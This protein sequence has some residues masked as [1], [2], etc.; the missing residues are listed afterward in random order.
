MTEEKEH[1]AV[2]L[3]GTLLK[4]EGWKNE[5]MFGEPFP[6]VIDWINNRLAEGHKVS[7]F[8]AREQ[9]DKVKRYLKSVGF[10]DIPVTNIKGNTFTLMIDDRAMRFSN[11]RL[12]QDTKDS[13]PAIVPWWKRL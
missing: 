3:D 7:V 9:L 8:T 1:Y 6:G 5:D 4:Y 2:D 11:P 10:P 13:F 12:W